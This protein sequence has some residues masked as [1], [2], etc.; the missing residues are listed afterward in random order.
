MAEKMSTKSVLIKTKKILLKQK[1]VLAILAMIV[2]MLFFDT[3]FFTVYN[4]LNI[5]RS[6]TVQG[7]IA[8]GVT[9]TVLCAACDL[10]VG[11]T[12]CLSGVIAVLMINF[13]VP[14]P[15]ACLCALLSGA[16]VGAVNGFLVVHQRTEP[17][18]ITLGMGTLLK[19]IS[20]LLTDAH[21]IACTNMSFMQIANTKI[22]GQIPI[23]ILYMLVIFLL[24]FW[25]L[26][27]TNYGRNCY[28]IGGNYEVAKYSGINTLAIKWSAFIISGAMAALAGILLSS[29]MNSAS[30]VYGDNTGMLVNCGVVIGGTSFAGGVGGAAESFIGIFV[31]QLMTN[32]MDC[33]GIGSY[34]QELLQGI[35]IVLI[36]GFD[37]Y[38]RLKKR[39]HA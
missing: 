1:A 31:L 5:F 26:R 11:G 27:F 2:L 34:V 14:I 24:F 9:M 7:I 38:S 12:M 22:L 6:V 15:I 28:A 23:L 29:R 37:C 3:Q 10:S 39:E 33:L 13:G 8:M 18:I 36:L 17:F 35:I 30:S 20:Q 4:W 19:G 16:L 21:P 32:C 25:I